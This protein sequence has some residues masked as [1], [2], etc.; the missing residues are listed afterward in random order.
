MLYYVMYPFPLPY[1]APQLGIAI[2]SLAHCALSSHVPG[3]LYQTLEPKASGSH[4]I[5]REWEKDDT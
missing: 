4:C 3:T 2:P 5:Q 1:S